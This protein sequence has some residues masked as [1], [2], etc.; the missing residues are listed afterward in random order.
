VRVDLLQKRRTGG[1]RLDVGW[2]RR[3]I[4]ER[5]LDLLF[6]VSDEKA[7]SERVFFSVELGGELVALSLGQL[8]VLDDAEFELGLQFL[9]GHR[10]LREEFCVRRKTWGVGHWM[11]EDCLGRPVGGRIAHCAQHRNC[12]GCQPP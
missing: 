2:W 12:A 10:V 3:D 9:L 8:V 11:L 5:Q 7:G 6:R 1:E 4:D